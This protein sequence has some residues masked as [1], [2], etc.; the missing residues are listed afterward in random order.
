MPG[1]KK[2]KSLLEEYSDKPENSS[3][4]SLTQINMM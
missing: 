2:N 1:T 3:M 4:A